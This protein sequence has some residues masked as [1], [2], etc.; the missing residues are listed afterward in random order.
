MIPVTVDARIRARGRSST[1][2]FGVVND[3]LFGPLMTYASDPEHARLVRAPV[4]RGDVQRARHGEGARSTSDR[5]RQSVLRRPGRRWAP[6]R[7]SSRRSPSCSGNDYEKVDVEGV[8]LTIGIDRGAEDR[9]ARARVARR[10]AAARRPHRA[11]EGAAAHLSR[12]GDRAH[13][14]DR[15]SGQRQRHRC[16]CWSPTAAR[17][18]PDRAARGARAAAARASTR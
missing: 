16:R 9:D 5:V 7:T 13:A 10:S 8:D 1:F 17:L 6:P 3:Q 11:A 15:H 2:H 14:A 12:R 4:R 18:G